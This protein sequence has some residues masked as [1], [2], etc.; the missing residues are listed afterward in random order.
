[1]NSK[2]VD[3]EVRALIERS[4]LIEKPR[5]RVVNVVELRELLA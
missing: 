1:M 3:R 4:E 5:N 2:S